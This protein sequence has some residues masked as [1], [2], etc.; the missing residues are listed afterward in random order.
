VREVIRQVPS[1]LCPRPPVYVPPSVPANQPDR[2]HA[3]PEA[4][5]PVR[6]RSRVAGTCAAEVSGTAEPCGTKKA[7]VNANWESGDMGLTPED[8]D[9]ILRYL[10]HSAFD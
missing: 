9:E 6:P 10:E 3:H 1:A 8:V 4:V 5:P 7:F 2:C